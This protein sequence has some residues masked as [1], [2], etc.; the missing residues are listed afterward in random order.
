MAPNRPPCANAYAAAEQNCYGT[1][2]TTYSFPVP[3]DALLWFPQQPSDRI[4]WV[5]VGPVI[6][7]PANL[8]RALWLQIESGEDGHFLLSAGV[9]DQTTNTAMAAGAWTPVQIPLEQ[10]FWVRIDRTQAEAE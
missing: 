4:S 1:R 5:F 2:A 9:D 10:R 3:L 6:V 7:R 8:A